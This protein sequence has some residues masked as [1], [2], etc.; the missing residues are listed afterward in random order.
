MCLD[1]RIQLLLKTARHSWN[2]SNRKKFELRT[3]CVLNIGANFEYRTTGL[4]SH[5]GRFVETCDGG[6]QLSEPVSLRFWLDRQI[7]V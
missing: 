1:Y 2:S 7:L 3:V 4:A 6:A 5:G